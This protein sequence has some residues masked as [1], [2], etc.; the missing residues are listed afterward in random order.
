M[1]Y[2]FASGSNFRSNCPDLILAGQSAKYVT[3][4][5]TASDAYS[6]LGEVAAV[7]GGNSVTVSTAE[8][9]QT[10]NLHNCTIKLANLPS[11]NFAVATCLSGRGHTTQEVTLGLHPKSPVSTDLFL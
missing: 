2:N 7:N 5:G 10:I 4:S 1:L 9:S 3:S 8:G 6:G 11:Y